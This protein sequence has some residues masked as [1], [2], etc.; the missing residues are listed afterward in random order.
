MEGS[1][2]A[3]IQSALNKESPSTSMVQASSMGHNGE[4][5]PISLQGGSGGFPSPGPASSRSF[6]LP[7]SVHTLEGEFSSVDM[8]IPT[9]TVEKVGWATH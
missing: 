8:H 7:H 6:S 5:V 4:N 9:L 2:E 3:S 1:I